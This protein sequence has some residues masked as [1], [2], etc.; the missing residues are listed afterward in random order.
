MKYLRNLHWIISIIIVIIFISLSILAINEAKYINK[1]RK[2]LAPGDLIYRPRQ[3][4]PGLSTSTPVLSPAEMA[5][6]KED[7][8]KHTLPPL[9]FSLSTS[10]PVLS[11]AEM[12]GKK[13]DPNKHTLPPADPTIIDSSPPPPIDKIPQKENP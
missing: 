7:P 3:P 13:E 9:E 1:I 12:A 2:I 11:P 5:G 8:N 4:I 10:T 6:K